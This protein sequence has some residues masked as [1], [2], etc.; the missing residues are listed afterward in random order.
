[1]DWNWLLQ[2]GK[3]FLS[4]FIQAL[5][6]ALVPALVAALVAY[7]TRKLQ[8]IKLAQPDITRALSFMMPIFVQAAEQ[9]KLAELIE[10]KKEYAISL[11]QTW[12]NEKGWKL[13]LAL[14]SGVVE[15][16]VNEAEFPSTVTTT[17]KTVKK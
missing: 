15:Q 10:D 14:I 9:A 7:I 4:Y 17:T 13:D 12:L 16:A 1:M 6:V 2:A 8:E 11:A 3:D 5:T